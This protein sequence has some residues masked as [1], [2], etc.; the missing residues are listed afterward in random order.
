M[1]IGGMDCLNKNFVS[2]INNNEGH[3]IEDKKKSLCMESSAD[4]GFLRF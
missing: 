4:R 2:L 1:R 3:R